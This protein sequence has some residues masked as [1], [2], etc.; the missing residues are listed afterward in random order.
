MMC[1]L[2]PHYMLFVYLMHQIPVEL[3]LLDQH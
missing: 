3:V 2:L 1:G